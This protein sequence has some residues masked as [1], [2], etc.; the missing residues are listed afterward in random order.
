M[1]WY[2]NILLALISYMFLLGEPDLDT[3]YASSRML[4]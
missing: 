4:S 3:D 2:C 1:Y